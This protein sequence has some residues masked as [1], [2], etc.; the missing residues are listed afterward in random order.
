MALC[1]CSLASRACAVQV[2]SL[3]RSL[4]WCVG[5]V[6]CHRHM[7]ALCTPEELCRARQ[8]ALRSLVTNQT[9]EEVMTV[10]NNAAED[11]NIFWVDTNVSDGCA[12]PTD[13]RSYCASMRVVRSFRS[14]ICT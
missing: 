9:H 7:P 11:V 13:A 12:T 3:V 1:C 4:Q 6:A 14:T 10:T 5:A 8:S 2:R